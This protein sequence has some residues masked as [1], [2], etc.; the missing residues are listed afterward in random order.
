MTTYII[1]RLLISIP[2]LLAITVMAFTLVNLAPGDPVGALIDPDTGAEGVNEKLRERY[3]LNKS[4]PERYAIWL[5]ELFKGNLG[6]SYIGGQSTLSMIKRRLIPT[7]EL[8][9]TA[10]VLSTI[11]GI[12]FGVIAA[13]KQYSI[14]DYGLTIL[15]LVGISVP[16]FFFALM[17]L[18]VFVA[19]LNWFPSFGW[20]TSG[21]DWS[22]WDNM[23]HL[24]L[25]ML[26]L[27]IE[28]MAGGTR[29]ART[30]LLE[31]LKADYVTTARAKGLAGNVVLWRHAF[32]NAI[33]P[34]I[35]ITT[36]RLPGLFGGALLIEFMFAWPGMGQLF[37]RSAY[38]R[39]YTVI[40]SLTLI[41]AIL[42]LGANLMADIMYAY[43]D[44]RIRVNR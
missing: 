9:A 26:V 41:T 38:N 43:A 27:A 17:A 10:M 15:A 18:Y 1:R 23:Y 19:L 40:T 16:G 44:P 25:P 13:L 11:G 36:L 31:V 34:V 32:R 24:A 3:G 39:D 8:T 4:I 21:K 22:L 2:M 37:I 7:L 14:W 12:F 35:T 6:Y 30:A 29:Y 42:V 5:R 20:L 33:I 28:S